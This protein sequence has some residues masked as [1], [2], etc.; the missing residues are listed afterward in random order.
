MTNPRGP[1][2]FDPET[3]EYRVAGRRVLSVTQIL[4]RAGLASSDWYS[5]DAA[6]RGTEVHRLL[7]NFDRGLSGT[8]LI[9]GPYQGYLAAY[10][11]FIEESG[12]EYSEI[13]QPEYSDTY[14]FAGTP[15]RTARFGHRIAVLDIKT[16]GAQPW[17]ALQTAAY[18]L[19][20][21]NWMERFALY[22]RTDG[23]YRLVEHGDDTDYDVFLAALT[24]VN[25]RRQQ[26]NPTA[27]PS[28]AEPER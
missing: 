28:S 6:R 1:L 7:E 2:A 21:G 13:E 18:A 5:E 17:H 20:V 16:G 8:L 11:R 15:D 19:L 12:I 9:D 14:G 4:H 27:R 10:G 22:L 3:H 24:V 26:R 23:T 25:W